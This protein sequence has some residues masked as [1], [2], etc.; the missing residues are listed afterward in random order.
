KKESIQVFKSHISHLNF[1]FFC[2]FGTTLSFFTY[3]FCP[4]PYFLGSFI[5]ISSLLVI[6]VSDISSMLIS[7]FTTIGLIPVGILCALFDK[8]PISALQSIIGSISGYL[9]LW[10][11]ATI[12]YKRTGK[13]GLGEG[14]MDMLAMIGSF[15]GPIGWW[16]TITLASF[17]GCLLGLFIL[18]KTG[19]P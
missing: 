1:Y 9:F 14:D 19:S 16:F 3:Y 7:T 13:D 10:F 17:V 15:L 11:I 6:I 8:L 2:I 5:F 4:A 18:I 12:Y